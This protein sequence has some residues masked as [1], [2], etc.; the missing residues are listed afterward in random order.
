MATAIPLTLQ[1]LILI[2]LYELAAG[3]AL[4]SGRIS[5]PAMLDDFDRSPALTFMTGF[6]V[7]AIG[8]IMTLVHNHWTDLPAI[9]VSAVSWIALIEGL[10]IMTMPGPLMAFARMLVGTE[11]AFSL[12][13]ISLGI[14]LIALGFTGR[15]DPTALI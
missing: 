4:L 10:L 14:I 12:F 11:R 6:V 7:Y 15:A 13:A 3:L 9:I 2:G 5:Y 8:A 1:L